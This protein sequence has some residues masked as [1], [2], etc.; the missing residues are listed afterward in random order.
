MWKFKAN[1]MQQKFS[2]GFCRSDPLNF[3]RAAELLVV[4]QCY[5]DIYYADGITNANTLRQSHFAVSVTQ[6]CDV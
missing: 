2:T 3:R 1:G 4:S 5:S 6:L